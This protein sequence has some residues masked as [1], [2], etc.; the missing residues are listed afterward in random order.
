[1]TRLQPSEGYVLQPNHYYSQQWFDTE[2][3][4]LFGRTWTF[5]GLEAQLSEVGAYL[6]V[7]VGCQPM[8]VTRSKDG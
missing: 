8:L 7:E 6:L 4:N 2:Q 3:K 5:A 1:M